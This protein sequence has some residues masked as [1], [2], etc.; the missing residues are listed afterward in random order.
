MICN[1]DDPLKT[2]YFFDLTAGLYSL[3]YMPW[4]LV[5]VFSAFWAIFLKSL[6]WS[7]VYLGLFIA[8]FPIMLLF[9]CNRCAYYEETCFFYLS[10]LSRLVAKKREGSAPL[11]A[12]IPFYLIG[13]LTVAMPQYWLVQDIPLLIIF[14]LATISFA[15]GFVRNMCMHCRSLGCPLNCVP[16]ALKEAAR[17]KM[18]KGNTGN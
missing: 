16:A 4:F 7:L 5:I 12:R 15:S 8:W 3:Q 6:L 14:W 17:E 1:R 11:A 18:E 2:D 9:F 10:V 13:F